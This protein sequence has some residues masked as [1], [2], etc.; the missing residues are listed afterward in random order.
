MHFIFSKSS[1]LNCTA[2]IILLVNIYSPLRKTNTLL[3]ICF[4]YFLSFHFVCLSKQRTSAQ[5]DGITTIVLKERRDRY[6]YNDSCDGYENKRSWVKLYI[7]HVCSGDI[8]FSK[9]ACLRF[10]KYLQRIRSSWRVRV[11]IRNVLVDDKQKGQN[12]RQT[13]L[14]RT[15]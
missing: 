2:V 4:F 13:Y 11:L 15:S 3:L 6:L 12:R 14:A 8:K 9:F 7:R 10:A 5:I 1:K